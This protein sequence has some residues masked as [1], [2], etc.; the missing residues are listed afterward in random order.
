VTR[1]RTYR[2][3]PIC[4]HAWEAVEDGYEPRDPIGVGRTEAE[5]IADLR[6]Q[7]EERDE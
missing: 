5:A 4:E 1:I 3:D 2:A 6:A 7:I